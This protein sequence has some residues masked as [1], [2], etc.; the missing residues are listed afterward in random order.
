VLD[1]FLIIGVLADIG[2]ERFHASAVLAGFLLDLK[3]GV[4][5]FDIVEDD[6]GAGLAKSLTAAAPIPR[7][8]PVMSARLACE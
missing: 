6:I 2:F 4:L 3:R 1:K 8:P 7:E 5:G